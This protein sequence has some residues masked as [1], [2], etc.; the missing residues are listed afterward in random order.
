[1]HNNNIH[2]TYIILLNNHKQRLNTYDTTLLHLLQNTFDFYLT[3]KNSEPNQQM[4]KTL[5][6]YNQLFL[7]LI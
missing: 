7:Y 3:S 2:H 1:M 5:S 4:H 6:Q